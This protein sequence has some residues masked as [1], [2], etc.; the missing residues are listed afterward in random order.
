[1]TAAQY[2]ELS[3]QRSDTLIGILVSPTGEVTQVKIDPVEGLFAPSIC[4]LMEV[5]RFDTVRVSKKLKIHKGRQLVLLNDLQIKTDSN[6]QISS[7]FKNLGVQMFG[8]VI[9]LAVK[10]NICASDDY[11][12]S[13]DMEEFKLNFLPTNTVSAA[14]PTRKPRRENGMTVDE[15]KKAKE[16]MTAKMNGATANIEI[17]AEPASKRRKHAI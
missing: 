7:F 8:N 17:T 5:D 12:V 9:L 11:L 2:T 15:F 4:K 16:Q 3:K 14:A 6:T 13:F 1:M 10:S